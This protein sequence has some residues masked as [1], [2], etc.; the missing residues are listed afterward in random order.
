MDR[1][2][3]MPGSV[4]LTLELLEAREVPSACM[5]NSLG[6]AGLGTATDHGDLRFCVNRANAIAGPDAITLSVTGTIKLNG[7]LPDLASEI[8]ITGPGA[9]LLKVDGTNHAHVFKV[10]ASGV[11]SI[12]GLTVSGGYAWLDD[13]GGIWNAGQ[14]TLVACAVSGNVAN[15]GTWGGAS[16]GGIYNA[17]TLTVR[18]ST[19][20]GNKVDSA[21]YIVA[22]AGIYNAGQL[23]L[24]NSTVSG[25]EIIG[26]GEGYGGGLYAGGT[27]RIR[28]STV[29]KNYDGWCE[30]DSG[31]GVYAA[32]SLT[33]YD[34]IVAGN[35]VSWCQPVPNV[36]GSYSGDHNV[37]DV[38][39][40]L[41]LLQYNGGP[42]MTHK[43]LKGSPAIDAGD[44]T[45]A[46]DWDQRGPGYPRIVNGTIDIGSYEV[47]NTDAPAGGRSV[48]VTGR[49]TA[50][51]T[52]PAPQSA[53]AEPRQPQPTVTPALATAP[54]VSR[55]PAAPSRLAG[56]RPAVVPELGV[57]GLGWYWR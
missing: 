21:V 5:V 35:T 20:S 12:S 11:V 28:F 53:P 2:P 14:L 10:S 16:G 30:S 6:D 13:G 45:G 39:P 26:V 24:D 52:F 37:I 8:T 34:A 55:T 22:G 50:P 38:D 48:L 4:R 42:T 7:E 36:Y 29:T 3:R 46:P 18:D 23:Y 31:P 17:G 54:A 19:V 44:N 47:Q 43:V 51:V 56:H 32:G 9:T 15:G 33:L 27:V 41:G 49:E 1:F 25:N 57:E 40:R